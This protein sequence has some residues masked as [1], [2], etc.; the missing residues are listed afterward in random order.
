M[1]HR[2]SSC[3]PG[4]HKPPVNKIYFEINAR[5]CAAA[6]NAAG[7]AAGEFDPASAA[8]PRALH[9]AARVE[10]LA[11]AATARSGRRNYQEG[12]KE[13]DIEIG[14]RPAWLEWTKT[15]NR[16]DFVRLRIWR[17]GAVWTPTLRQTSG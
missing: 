12:F 13:A 17:C 15:L 7:N 8:G 10:A 9:A 4:M 5:T 6:A 11:L 3:I 2:L 1:Q 16:T 14:S